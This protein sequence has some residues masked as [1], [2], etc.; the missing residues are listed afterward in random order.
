VR[1]LVDFLETLS[2]DQN[3][4]SLQAPSYAD[5]APVQPPAAVEF[6]G[7]DAVDIL[8]FPGNRTIPLAT[9][10]FHLNGNGTLTVR[11]D[12]GSLRWRSPS[13]RR[14]CTA[15][16]PCRLRFHANGMVRLYQGNENYWSAGPS[17]TSQGPYKMRVRTSM[18]LRVING[19]G[20]T[21]VDLR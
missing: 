20:A 9:G 21:V 19:A 2:S 8:T 15:A 1:D 12:D 14:E 6:S 11:V 4:Y 16:N 17:N 10:G 7:N 5:P 18:P 13:P 3:S